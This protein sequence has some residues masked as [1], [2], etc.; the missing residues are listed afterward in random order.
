MEERERENI[1]MYAIVSHRIYTRT[2][3]VM[4]IVN[5]NNIIVYERSEGEDAHGEQFF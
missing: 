3:I 2:V 1:Y 4:N 5:N